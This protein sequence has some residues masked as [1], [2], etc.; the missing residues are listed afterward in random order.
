MS[1]A[2]SS[3]A[4]ATTSAFNSDSTQVLSSSN[5]ALSPY[6]F[7][8]FSATAPRK[9]QAPYPSVVAGPALIVSIAFAPTPRAPFATRARL[10]SR[11][12]APLFGAKLTF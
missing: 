3:T 10:A 9:Q 4:L 11:R 2:Q 5:L 7:K 12:I 6:L 8:Y 1:T